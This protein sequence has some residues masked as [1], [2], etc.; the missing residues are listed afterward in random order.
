[1]L[2][3]IFHSDA[4]PRTVLELEQAQDAA[5]LDAAVEQARYEIAYCD[6]SSVS[7]TPRADLTVGG[8]RPPRLRL[9]VPKMSSAT[10]T[11]VAL[12]GVRP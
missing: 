5:V 10:L 2:D 1:L 6:A 7:K 9:C 3:Q 12:P 8:A 11:R 4:H